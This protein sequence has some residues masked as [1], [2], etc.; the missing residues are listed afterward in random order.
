MAFDQ[1]GES[2]AIPGTVF[3]LLAL[4]VI[5]V[6]AALVWGVDNA[7]TSLRAEA[8]FTLENDE[9]NIAV[10]FSGRDARLIGVVES[11]VVADEV[12]ATVD[13][14]DGVRL[15]RSEIVVAAPEPPPPRPAEI[16]VRLVGGAV[17]LRGAV[18]SDDVATS[19]VEA[20]EDAYGSDRVIVS[21]DIESNVEPD[22]WLNFVPAVFEHL[23]DL[24]SGGFTADAGGLHITGE[25]VSESVRDQIISEVK[26]VIGDQLAVTADLTIA[27]LPPPIFAA[28]RTGGILLL[29]GTMPNR[30]TADRIVDA[31]ERLHPDATVVD[32]LRIGDVAGPMWLE[33]VEGLL[34]IVS[35]LDAWTIDVTD[36]TVS[37]AG[38][39]NDPDVVSA[40][41]V[42]VTEVVGGELTAVTAVE[43]KPSA[44]A[45]QLTGL[46]EGVVLFEPGTAVLTEEG[47]ELLDTAVAILEENPS[48]VL[49]VEG[50]TDNQGNAA[51]NLQLS[52]QRAEGV[53]TY[54]VAGGI[55]AGRLS[56][57]GFGEEQPVASNATEEGR[58]QNRR[59]VFVIREGDA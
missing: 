50:H 13:A 37:I 35:R 4:W 55:D 26:V 31:A 20:A 28:E 1:S 15:V 33:S 14:I 3:W 59:I 48:S 44:L 46:V 23:T 42:L 10:D 34:D 39:G 2:G 51:T 57:I 19:L 6:L 21:L 45:V 38:F 49:V 53:V 40:V 52:Q 9:H 12:V 27:V 18:P 54:L 5:V 30:E 25:V 56:A 8:R 36:R 32:A 7:E 11:D 43:V 58:A 22:T 17:A 47:A 16:D 29:E 24:R 41:D